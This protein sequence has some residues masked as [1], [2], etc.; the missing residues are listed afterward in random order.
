MDLIELAEEFKKRYICL[1]ENTEKQINFSAS[2]EKEVTRIDENG[3]EITKIIS[4]RLRFIDRVRFM[5]K[6]LSN[7]VNNLSK[8]IH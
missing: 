6:S 1:G 7:L 5:E 2:I 8:E 4:Y 3:K